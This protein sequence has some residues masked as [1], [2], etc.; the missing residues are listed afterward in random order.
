MTT[1]TSQ[2][3]YS[4]QPGG[5]N[6]GYSDIMGATMEYYINDSIDT[7]DFNLGENLIG[8][9]M[10]GS[11]LRYMENPPQDG[12]SIDDVC[13]FKR[14]L[15]VHYSSGVLN[16]AFTSAVRSCQSSG[17][18]TERECVLLLGSLFMYANIH[19]L[20]ALSGYLD[21][22]SQTCGV[23]D[24]FYSARSPT[25]SCTATQAKE[26]VT[27][28]WAAAGVALDS[29]CR[30]TTARGCVIPNTPATAGSGVSCFARVRA[31]IQ[32]MFSWLTGPFSD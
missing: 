19:K 10:S 11:I 2:L 30:A 1:F 4:H 9:G 28:G 17:C 25:T 27:T 29:S 13:D 18:S 31:G 12:K 22:A 8:G 24:E 3:I 7:P 5:L 14:D 21:S 20:T 26:F 23:V 6:E 32:T 16:K 15:N